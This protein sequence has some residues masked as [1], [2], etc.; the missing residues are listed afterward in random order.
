MK[1]AS[2]AGFAD[3][4][5]FVFKSKTKDVA[6]ANRVVPPAVGGEGDPT[7]HGASLVVY[8]SAG[9]GEAFGEALPAGDW[10]ALGSPASPK[11]FKYKTNDP[12][13]SVVRVVVKRDLLKVK[14]KGAAWGY[15]LDEPTQG[16][17]AVRFG[18]GSAAPWCADTPGAAGRDEQDSFTGVKDAPAPGACPPVP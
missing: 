14:A 6:P 17:I 16:S 11:G 4:R 3:A 9:T 10:I 1:D 13:R 12:A 2:F 8:N 5:K 7:L 18:L 15:T